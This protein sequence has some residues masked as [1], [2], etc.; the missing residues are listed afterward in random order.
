M[1]RPVPSMAAIAGVVLS[2]SLIIGCSD[3]AV[4]PSGSGGSPAGGA[5]GNRANGGTVGSGGASGRGGV[6]GGGGATAAAGTSGA[7]GAAG[8]GGAGGVPGVGGHAG[9][10]GAQGGRGGAA[11]GV[12]I[13][14]AGGLSS[15]TATSCGAGKVCVS[16][17]ALGTTASVCRN[18]PC[19]GQTLS[20]DCANAALCTPQAFGICNV[21]NDGTVACLNGG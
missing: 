11:G 8:R 17:T 2:L 13:G 7:A 14:G 5:A 19:S 6:S 10:A 18:N 4:S 21:T 9:G 20:C 1:N 16:Y 3:D 12:G 15:C